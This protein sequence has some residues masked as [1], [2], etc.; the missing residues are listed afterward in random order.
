MVFCL[1]TFCADLVVVCAVH[2]VRVSTA[3]TFLFGYNTLVPFEFVFVTLRT[4]LADE[5]VGSTIGTVL[6]DAGL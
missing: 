3:P 6:C 5:I 1:V 4:C 2:A